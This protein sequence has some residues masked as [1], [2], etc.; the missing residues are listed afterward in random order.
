MKIHFI[1]PE[2]PPP[3]DPLLCLTVNELARAARFRFPEDAAAWVRCR[4]TLRHIIGAD[5]GIP[6]KE[7]PLI[8]SDFGKP[9]LAAPYD[10]LHFNLSHCRDLALL[11]VSR[12]G[13]IGIDLEPASRAADLLGCENSFCHPAEI[14]ALADEKSARGAQ[15]LKIWV[16]KEALLK[17]IGTGFSIPP[18]KLQIIFEKQ[19]VQF[20]F[21]P[22]LQD[23]QIQRIVSLAHPRLEKFVAFLSYQSATSF[24]EMFYA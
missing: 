2:N 1:S 15:L 4:A 10:F 7:V 24:P 6:A 13:P 19:E 8:Y 3:G 17:A 12:H 5:L 9:M 14:S 20:L 11:A 21:D 18:E 23:A 22:P 16:A